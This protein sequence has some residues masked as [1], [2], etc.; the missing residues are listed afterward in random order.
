MKRVATSTNLINMAN[1]THTTQDK[2]L[3]LSN[4]KV[5][6]AKL[7]RMMTFFVARHL[8]RNKAVGL[9]STSAAEDVRV[10]T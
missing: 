5:V 8:Y 6:A 7:P 10:F 2:H 4:S 3:A 9:D 1:T